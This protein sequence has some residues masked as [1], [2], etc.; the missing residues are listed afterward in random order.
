MT[1]PI[2][3]PSAAIAALSVCGLDTSAFLFL[4]FLPVS[5]PER[6]EKIEDVVASKNLVVLYEAPHRSVVIASTN[7]CVQRI[8]STSLL[9]SHRF[10]NRLKTTLTDLMEAGAHDCGVVCGREL[11]KLHEEFFRGTVRE[12]ADWIQEHPHGKGEFVLVLE[13]AAERG[14]VGDDQIRG[15]LERL[16]RDGESRSEAVRVVSSTLDVNKR[17]VYKIALGM[18]WKSDEEP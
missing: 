10:E 8:S 1:H 2:P 13:G 16:M 7:F 5:G 11:T 14:P 12:L 15:Q 9:L 3:G 17:T 18:E 4:G 6:R